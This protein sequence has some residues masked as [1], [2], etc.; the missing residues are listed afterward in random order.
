MFATAIS[1][2][3]APEYLV[4]DNDLL[5]RYHRWHASLRVLE[6]EEI[7]SVPFVPQSHPYVE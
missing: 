2:N 7:K 3:S 6:I 4:S 1:G 5:F